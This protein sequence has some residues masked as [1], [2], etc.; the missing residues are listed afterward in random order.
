MSAV[1]LTHHSPHVAV[2]TLNNP[3]VNTLS[4]ASRADLIKVLAELEN[5]DRIR[6]VVLTGA[7]RAFTAGAD[8]R[9]DQVM[10]EEQLPDFLMDFDRIIRGIEEFRAPVI[11]AIN[12]PTVGG[13]L[14]VALACDIR[15][16]AD[17]ATFVAAGVNVGLMANFWRLTRVVGL[18]PATDILLTGEPCSADQAARYGLV[19][20]LCFPEALMEVALAKAERI[21]SRAPLSV[22]ATK[23]CVRAAPGMDRTEADRRQV[24]ELQQLFTSEDHQEALRAFFTKTTGNFHRR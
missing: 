7:G 3:P 6:A 1:E 23:R 12:G 17:N 11:A 13:G 5:D 20:Q 15:I 14:E 18:G 8:L 4:W 9:Q 22:E 24:A 16:A 10:S 19:T 2:I 21:A